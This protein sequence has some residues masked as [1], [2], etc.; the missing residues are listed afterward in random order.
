MKTAS[1]TSAT[2]R[3]AAITE[4][5]IATATRRY[6]LSG[7]AISHVLIEA[8][9]SSA[10]TSAGFR[11]RRHPPD[12]RLPRSVVSH[13]VV[14]GNSGGVLLTDEFGPTHHNV[15]AHHTVT[16]NLFDCGITVPG[17]NPFALDANGNRQ[18]SVAGVYDNVIEHNRITDNGTSG[19]GAGVGKNNTGGDPDAG[20]PST[21]GVLVLAEAVP[22]TVTISH[23]RIPNDEIGIWLGVAGNATATM[24]NN[25]FQNVT[26]T[27]FTSP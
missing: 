27:V 25:V 8:T 7:H 18:P 23:N 20:L 17:H 19:E 22:V 1:A 13:N 15:I 10:T 14:T 24:Q 26:T 16:K 3:V 11:R 6:R 21:T 2:S 12:G 5:Q 9:A 4:R